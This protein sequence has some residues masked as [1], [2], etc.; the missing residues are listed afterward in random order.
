[1]F[2]YEGFIFLFDK[3][4]KDRSIKFW[5]CKLKTKCNARLHTNAD[6]DNVIKFI[7]KHSHGSDADK[8]KSTIILNSIKSTALETTKS[9]AAI[10]NQTLQ[11]HNS[12]E[13]PATFPTKYAIKKMINR[14]RND[15]NS[16]P[17][18]PTKRM[19]ITL[20]PQ[21]QY[22][23]YADDEEEPFVL[24]DSGA[25]DANRI[26]IF[27]R[28]SNKEW[29]NKTQSL[30]IDDSIFINS[31]LFTQIYIILADR[32][33]FVLPILYALLP[34]K[35][36]DT[37]RRLFQCITDL[38]PDLNPLSCSLGLEQTGLEAVRSFFSNCTIMC[39]LYHL[40][41]EIKLKLREEHLLDFYNTD[42]KFALTTRMIVALAYVPINDLETAL[43]A[44][45]A[46]VSVELIPIVNWFKDK[47]MGRYFI[48]QNK[49]TAVFA[50]ENWSVFEKTLLNQDY[51]HNYVEATHR[52]LQAELELEK[53]PTLWKVIDGIRAVQKDCDN[54]FEQFV[55]GK[56]GS[57]ECDKHVYA[58][59][60]ILEI[61]LSYGNRTIIEYL[62]DISNNFIE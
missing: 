41:K 48:Q 30:Y 43:D 36:E 52:R 39:S 7:N 15:H 17:A 26:I 2:V 34:N 33:G 56:Q 54:K 60:R 37:F 10:I 22:Y 23:K 25:Q 3:Y 5:R 1:M 62:R 13:I 51:K 28:T 49:P 9:P 61:V 53:T 32:E 14:S 19:R 20:P 40:K 24:W 38:W 44:L 6:N 31:S 18:Q 4:N 57:E 12:S 42:P 27:G 21:Y 59:K 11:Q 16:T 58:D 8:V 45:I 47:Y 46:E 55:C 29:I 50:P 35:D